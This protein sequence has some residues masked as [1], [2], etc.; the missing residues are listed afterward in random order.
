MMTTHIPPRWLRGAADAP[1]T[2]LFRLPW[3]MR[4]LRAEQMCIFVVTHTGP[5]PRLHALDRKGAVLATA[6]LEEGEPGAVLLPEGTHRIRISCAAGNMPRLGHYP[7]S[8][9]ELKL[10][11][12]VQG[13]FDEPS[14]ARRW[15]AAGAAAR[16][17]RGALTALVETTGGRSRRDIARYQRFRARHVEDL[18]VV[19]A[20]DAAPRLAFITAAAGSS[21]A[22]LLACALALARQ[23]DPHFE[24]IIALPPERAGDAEALSALLR[25]AF[26]TFSIPPFQIVHARESS[27]PAQLQAALM[28]TQ[29]G[30]ICP[31]APDVRPTRDAVAMLRDAFARH[32]DCALAYSDEEELDSTG[33]PV[34]GIFKPAFNP[35][36]LQASFYMGHLLALKRADALRLG[37]APNAGQACLYDLLL[38][39]TAELMPAQVRHIPRIGCGAHGAARPGF[40]PNTLPQAAAMLERALG[41]P[42]EMSADGRHLRP[43]FPLPSP[44]PLVSIVIPTRDRADLLGMALRTLIGKTTYRAFEIIIVDN[45]SVEAETF[46]LFDEIRAAWPQTLIVRDDGD[47]NYPRICNTGVEQAKGELILLL[48]NDIEVIDG[49]W[50]SEMVSL[51]ALPRAGVVGAKLLYPD[52]TVQHAGVIVGLFRYA[53]HWFAHAGAQAGGYEDRLLVRQ[54][55]SAVTGACLLIRRDVWNITGPLD[56]VRFAEDCND[57]DLC[58]RARRAGFDVVFTPYTGLI[59]HESVSRG[60]KRSKA[61]RERLKAQRARMEECWGTSRMV[62]PH[63]NP[64]LARKGLYAA[65]ADQPEGPREP[66]TSEI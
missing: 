47:F 55:L 54:N 60:K 38:R 39:H 13:S 35:H 52:R 40:A 29:G 44:Q 15:K 12:F 23:N 37:F 66:R 64:N 32:D 53:G 25:P 28:A 9:V 45:G 4:A 31:L 63:Y 18:A 41:V 49:G 22:S 46:A 6:M 56:E 7:F 30:L 65:L 20:P 3:R 5:G 24:W 16:T 36:L 61:H 51:S 2:W 27:L 59:H 34:R 1:D 17:L 10:H 62:D 11:A 58:L 14:V 42:V 26:S 19:P 21:S 48:N 33:T 43:L 8:K 57:I 50:L